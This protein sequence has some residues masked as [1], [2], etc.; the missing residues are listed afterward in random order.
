MEQE[1]EC[2]KKAYPDMSFTE[3]RPTLEP[4]GTIKFPTRKA[5]MQAWR[6]VVRLSIQ[7]YYFGVYYT[8]MA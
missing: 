4:D 8:G 3:V 1:F 5:Y 2:F 7:K 6:D